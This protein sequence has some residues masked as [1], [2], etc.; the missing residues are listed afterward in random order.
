MREQQLAE[1]LRREVVRQEHFEEL[2][3][4]MGWDHPG[5]NEPVPVED[6][7][8]RPR[9]V[10][11][12][13]GVTA[14][15]AQCPAGVP[16]RQ[17]QRRVVQRLKKLSRDQLVVF[18]SPDEHLWLWPEQRPSGVGHRLV[19][20]RHRAGAP[21]QALL[22][23]LS[24]A[25]FRLDEERTLTATSVLARIRRSFN[26]D[27]ITKSFYGEFRKHHSDFV[28]SVEG[29]PDDDNRRWYVSVLLN[30]LMFIYFIQQKQFLDGDQHYLR[31]K[32]KQVRAR[33]GADQFYAY[34]R[35]FLLPLFRDGLGSAGTD[36]AGGTAADLIGEVP[37]VNGSIFERHRLEKMHQIDIRDDVFERLFDF[38]DSWRWHLD[39]RP[40]GADD[41]KDN[42][43]NPDI[44][45]YIFEQ[46]INYTEAG[47]KKNGAY[48]TKPDVTGYMASVTILPALADRF[49]EVGLDDPSI[50]LATSGDAYIHDS[51][52]HGVDNEMTRGGGGGSQRR[53]ASRGAGAAR[54]A[55]VRC[56]PP[57]R[58][59]RAATRAALGPGSRLGHQ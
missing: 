59:L 37:Y 50:L 3:R 26:A 19:D 22:Q 34:Y 24:Q 16:E 29:I 28:D 33:F 15:L 18:A 23:R 54:R 13:R 45:G 7:A 1:L 57:T 41:G 52:L 48:Y 9:A 30:R 14:W 51:I 43:I 21:T 40:T 6:S 4:R 10:A 55:V 36:Y 39:E 42:E 2:F 25:S 31:T 35:E 38:F 17:E 58:A 56:R 27:K 46:Y 20:Y 44:L 12:K 32:L 53:H 11:D 47:Q 49:A 8:L 5:S